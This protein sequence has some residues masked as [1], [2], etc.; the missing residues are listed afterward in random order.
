MVGLQ[1]SFRVAVGVCITGILFSVIR[2]IVV[3]LLQS[4][5]KNMLVSALDVHIINRLACKRAS[6]LQGRG[7]KITRFSV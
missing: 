2:A 6:D 3:N 5:G 4:E 7:N 1:G